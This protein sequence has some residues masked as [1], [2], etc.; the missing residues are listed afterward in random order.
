MGKMAKAT[1]SLVEALGWTLAPYTRVWT[2]SFA[3]LGLSFLFWQMRKN[4]PSPPTSQACCEERNEI[5]CGNS[6]LE[7]DRGR[8]FGRTGS[9]LP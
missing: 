9:A 1:R 5:M 3:L 7:T 2:N 4:Y 8:A 6:S